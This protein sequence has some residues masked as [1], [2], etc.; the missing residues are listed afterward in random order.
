MK[1]PFKMKPGRGNMPKTGKDIPLNMKSP[2]YMT[3]GPGD[4][5][6]KTNETSSSSQKAEV[7]VS[8]YKPLDKEHYFSDKKDVGSQV[9]NVT[10]E[11]AYE[12]DSAKHKEDDLRLNTL[13][14]G[15]KV[16]GTRYVIN[17]YNS[18]TNSFEARE[19]GTMNKVSISRRDMVKRMEPKIGGN[20]QI[21]PKK[22]DKFANIRSMPDN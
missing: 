13:K 16:P 3:D 15:S 7:H 22:I 12:E 9:V 4:K 20:Y 17:D 2:A 14:P 10:N 5:K 21:N 6:E 18:E 11:K 1:S 8:G 19:K